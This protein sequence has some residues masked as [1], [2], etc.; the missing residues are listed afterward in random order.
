MGGVAGL[1][2]TF[3]LI[4]QQAAKFLNGIWPGSGSAVSA[5]I[6]ATGTSAIGQAAIAYYIE[7]KTMD[8]AKKKFEATKNETI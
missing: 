2:Y 7:G 4:A 5:G 3:K 6:A 1:G 8:E